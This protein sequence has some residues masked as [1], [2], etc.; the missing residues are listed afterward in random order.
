M[1]SVRIACTLRVVATCII[2]AKPRLYNMSVS[3]YITLLTNGE[4]AITTDL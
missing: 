4:K 3:V 1:D 2:Y